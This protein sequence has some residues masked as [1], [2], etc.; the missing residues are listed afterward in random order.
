M[1]R[2]VAGARERREGRVLLFIPAYNCA[3][4]I[5]RVL[6]QLTPDV[7]ALLSEVIVV[8][9]RSGDG[10]QAA[11][12]AA[13][14]KLDGIAAKVLLNDD[15]YGLGG[16]HKVAFDYA[17]TNRFDYVIVLHGDDQGS[18]ADLAPL[19]RAGAHREV[20]CLLGAR[21][22]K[23][24]RLSGYSP[25][26][27]FGNRVFNAIYSLAAGKRIY[28]LGSGLNVY[29]VSSLSDRAWL[30]HANDLTFNYHMILGSIAGRQRIRFFP[31][32]WREDDQIS[33]V[34]LV[35]QS[36]RVLGIAAAYAF[37]RRRFLETDHS[38]RPEGRY[39]YRVVFSHDAL[40]RVS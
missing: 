24:S 5:P 11:A 34:K 22:M 16:S 13:L 8:D 25:L 21:F 39:G 37:D 6:A 20:D 35:R 2:E 4:Q 27:T 17:L 10:T 32:E 18:I 33:N 40:E 29:A 3:P 28:D 15:N 38:G 19:L 9:N 31:L 1:G 26:R 30:R 23:G 7:R 12:V 14:S 36:L